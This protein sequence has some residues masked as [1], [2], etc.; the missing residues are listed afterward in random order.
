[1]EDVGELKQKVLE[2]TGL[3]AQYRSTLV[4]LDDDVGGLRL[5]LREA[6]AHAA[7]AAAQLHLAPAPA[8]T[9]GAGGE[10]AE[11]RYL[12]SLRYKLR[13]IF[14]QKKITQDEFDT[15]EAALNA[16]SVQIERIGYTEAHYERDVDGV[17]HRS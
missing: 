11:P 9:N 17:I 14:E 8:L 7:A 6:K 16:A 5:Q 3:I 1:M 4:E 10:E 2:Q 12:A 15:A 13:E